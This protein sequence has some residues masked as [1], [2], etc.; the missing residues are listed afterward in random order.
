MQTIHER[1]NLREKL[2]K[3]AEITI[4][5]FQASLKKKAIG[6]TEDLYNSFVK[7]ITGSRDEMVS[8]MI[9]FN[10]YGRLRDMNVGRGLSAHER[11][12]NQTNRRGARLGAQ[13]N[14]VRRTPKK[15]Y[16]KT[17]TAQLYRLKEILSEDLGHDATA[18]IVD[19]FNQIGTQNINI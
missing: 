5:K 16:N 8:A 1:I 3:W 10:F 12:S 15:W 19:G 2:D 4:E 7:Q 18:M 13:V 17:K 14:F 9:K 6:V 11:S